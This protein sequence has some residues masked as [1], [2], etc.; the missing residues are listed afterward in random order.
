MV[1]HPARRSSADNLLRTLGMWEDLFVTRQLSRWQ[2]LAL[3]LV[4]TAGVAL[5]LMGLF[6]V[7]NRTWAGSGALHVQ[8]GFREI[9]G[10]EVG[11]RVRIQGMDA[12]EVVAIVAPD[13]P[14]DDVILRLTVKKSY[15]HLVR[16]HSVVQI[17]NEGLIGGKVLEIRPDRESAIAALPEDVPV[18]EDALLRSES[19][20]ELA[21][22][23]AQVSDTLHGIQSG[24]GT[25][26]KLAKDAAAYDALVGL[27]NKSSEAVEHSK[28]TMATIQRDADALKKLPLVGGYIEDPVQLLVRGKFEK[29]RQTFSEED[30]FEPGRAILTDAGRQRL[31]GLG[32]WLA[33]LRKKGSD[34]V[35]VSYADS[36][37]NDL[38]PS[39][40]LT[41]QQSESVV[42]YLRK[43][44]AVQ[45]LGWW[46]SRKVTPLGQGTLPPPLP[47]RDPLPAARVEVL[48]FVPQG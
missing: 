3:G 6:A 11:T 25:I 38:R 27:L 4:V 45:K 21:D 31:D 42:E 2:A 19:P 9:H 17:A 26:G 14:Q 43:K 23:L 32:P 35:V 16:T 33:G 41:R 12:G 46:S 18:D 36:R 24:Q 39:L 34:V 28:D 44:H 29:N 37:K 15:R 5:G 40:E 1:R 13:R 10:V 7:G 20:P 48:V 8:V 22:I 30:L 47:E